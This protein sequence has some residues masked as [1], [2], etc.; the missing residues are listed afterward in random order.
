MPWATSFSPYARTQTKTRSCDGI[1]TWRP[2][3]SCDSF[4][5]MQILSKRKCNGEKE[6]ERKQYTSA[7][8]NNCWKNN[9]CF[10]RREYIATAKPASPRLV[11]HVI[12]STFNYF[13]TFFRLETFRLEF[14]WLTKILPLELIFL[15][16]FI[17]RFINLKW[18]LLD[19]F[20]FIRKIKYLSL[21]LL[22]FN[23]L[24]KCNVKF[25]KIIYFKSLINTIM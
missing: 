21:N 4:P 10:Y 2:S 18:K 12:S 23:A 16:I 3:G 11:Q 24:H 9:N 15:T 5:R 1:A 7:W 25:Y 6:R 20:F 8:S 19:F 14:V 22:K 17:W 13:R